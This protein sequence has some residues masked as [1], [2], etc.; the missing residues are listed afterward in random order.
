MSELRP[1]AGKDLAIATGTYAHRVRDR[2]IPGSDAA[3]DIVMVGK[4]VRGFA[5]SDKVVI[6]Y[7][8]KTRTGPIKSWNWGLGGPIDG[9]MRGTQ[10]TLI[11]DR[12]IVVP[13]DLKAV[14]GA[15]IVHDT[16]LDIATA[17][18][19]HSG[20][21]PARDRQH[22]SRRIKLLVGDPWCA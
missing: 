21:A 5:I 16:E 20:L 8:Q 19:E 12:R 17:F 15:I 2:V 18:L 7:D 22:V 6:A 1:W 9:V 14:M 3:G 11:G 4:D 10:S 13:R